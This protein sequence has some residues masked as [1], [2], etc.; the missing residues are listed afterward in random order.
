MQATVT[1]CQHLGR[2]S[3]RGVYSVPFW[4]LEAEAQVLAWFWGRVHT[5]GTDPWVFMGQKEDKITLWGSLYK[6]P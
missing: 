2:L 5:P 6:Q 3:A 4:S 1:E